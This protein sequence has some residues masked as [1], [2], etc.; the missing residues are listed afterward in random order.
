MSL[1]IVWNWQTSESHTFGKYVSAKKLRKST[2][3]EQS[4]AKQLKCASTIC[5]NKSNKFVRERIIEINSA[6]CIDS[7]VKS[8]FAGNFCAWIT[9]ITCRVTRVKWYNITGT[10]FP[11]WEQAKR[12]CWRACKANGKCHLKLKWEK[13]RNCTVKSSCNWQQNAEKIHPWKVSW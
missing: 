12:R 1:E 6:A 10:H 2:K 3:I 7:Q 4:N 9:S 13:L 5:C 8:E 11:L